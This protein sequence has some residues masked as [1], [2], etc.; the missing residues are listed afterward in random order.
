MQIE[1]TSGDRVNLQASFGEIITRSN[2]V[3]LPK[4]ARGF[5]LE[6]VQD[7]NTLTMM[8]QDDTTL[9]LTLTVADNG[10]HPWGPIKRF[11][12]TGTTAGIRVIAMY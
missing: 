6:N 2:T 4:V 8:F 10:Y 1:N 7:G 12:V 5:R 3:D 9:Q 11:L